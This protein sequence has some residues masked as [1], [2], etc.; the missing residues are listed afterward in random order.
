MIFHLQRLPSVCQAKRSPIPPKT[1]LN[2]YHNPTADVRPV[3]G[4]CFKR[5]TQN[6]EWKQHQTKTKTTK[7]NKTS[8]TE[9]TQKTH[10]RKD[11]PREACYS[12]HELH[13]KTKPNSPRKRKRKTLTRRQTTTH[14]N[15]TR[16]QDPRTTRGKHIKCVRIANANH[17]DVW[18]R[19]P[20]PASVLP[21]SETNI[22]TQYEHP[23]TYAG[24]RT[25]TN[26][27]NVCHPYAGETIR[28]PHKHSNK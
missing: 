7:E 27:L 2:G 1:L 22:N 6:V 28:H 3:P 5:S 19:G 14:P 23:K 11:N 9:S 17:S 20:S 10:K 12:I 24:G 15:H 26:P 25:T 16:I 4:E 8:T 13:K 21:T 18:H